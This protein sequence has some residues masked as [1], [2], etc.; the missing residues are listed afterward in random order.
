MR[1][2]RRAL[3][4]GGGDRRVRQHGT[5]CGEEI[6]RLELQ[7]VHRW[8]CTSRLRS[9]RRA[10]GSRAV[11]GRLR[12]PAGPRQRQ[13]V[14]ADSPTFARTHSTIAVVVAPGVKTLATPSGLELRD[15][16]LGDDPAAEDDD[17]VGAALAQQLHHPGE[18]RHVR[19]GQ[20]RQADASASSW[21]VVS[22]ICSGR[23]VQAGVDDLH[24]RVA[25][26]PR[27]DL[28]PAVVPV[29]A[30]AWRRRRGCDRRWSRGS[31]GRAGRPVGEY[32]AVTASWQARCCTA[33]R[34]GR[35]AGAAPR[36]GRLARLRAAAVAS[37]VLRLASGAVAAVWDF[38]RTAA[39]SARTTR[40]RWW[41]RPTWPAPSAAAAGDRGA[42]RRHPAAGGHGGAGRHPARPARPA[43]AG[44]AGL[45]HLSVADAPTTGGVWI[46]VVSAA[47]LRVAVAGA[48]VGFAGPRVVRGV[49]GRRRRRAATARSR[50]YAAGLVD[51]VLPADDVPAW[52][53]AALRALT[54]R[55]ATSRRC[56]PRAGSPERRRLGAGA[57]LARPR[58]TGGAE[59]LAQ[60][61]DDARGPAR[62]A[63]RRTVGAVVG[64]AAGR[65]AVG[66][67]LAARPGVRPTPGRLPPRRPRVPARRPARAAG[68]V[69][70]GHPRRRAGQPRPRT[71][72][73]PRPWAP[74]WTPCCT[75]RRATVALVHGEGGSGGALAAA[76]TDLLVVM[77]PTAGS[78]RSRP[79][80]PRRRC[81]ARAEECADLLRLRPPTCSPLGAADALVD[82][83]RDALWHLA[84][85]PADGWSGAP[86]AGGAGRPAT[87]HAAPLTRRTLPARGGDDHGFR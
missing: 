70:R 28:G 60:L 84:R 55:P 42:Q 68:A 51:A 31:S 71:T 47:D 45:P 3:L 50:A 66:V 43:R 65:P 17:V 36:P 7:E 34:R 30:R 48:T 75:C 29:E 81:A 5:P 38:R 23:L 16:V 26:G 12:G 4:G 22:T 39:A 13:A 15:V 77:T 6:L 72:G 2:A 82:D 56:R 8:S 76:V 85:S 33:A 11:A 79:R 20:H 59:L 24:A 63:R 10:R 69:A 83:P 37:R 44:R 62:A 67:A 19:A 18:Q 87:G 57:A 74:R 80:G 9:G 21:I 73:S 53:A 41:P 54:P 14:G 86:P 49:T 27:D 46:S 1:S 52:V 78:P 40:R 25:Q 35:R 32:A 64:R 61:L 58:R